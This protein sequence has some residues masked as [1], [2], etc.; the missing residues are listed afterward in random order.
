VLPAFLPDAVYAELGEP[1][2]PT[3]R[4][5]ERRLAAKGRPFETGS[6]GRCVN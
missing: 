1:E 2:A 4:V 3:A 5:D 6:T